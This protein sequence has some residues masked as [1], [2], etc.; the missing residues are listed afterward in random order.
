[1]LLAANG[2]LVKRPFLLGPCVALV[3]FEEAG[4]REKLSKNL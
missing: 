2:N 3:G 4:W 1:K